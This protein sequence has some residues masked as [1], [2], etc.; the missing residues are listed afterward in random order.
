MDGNSEVEEGWEPRVPASPELI[1]RA[2][3]LVRAFPECFWFRHPEAGMCHV[4][5]I[6]VVVTHLREYGGHN[7]WRQA[8]TLKRCL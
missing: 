2:T 3:A 1:E 6:R 4:Q 7:A 8:Q 5:D